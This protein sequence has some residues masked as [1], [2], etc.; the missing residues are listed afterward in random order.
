MERI[1]EF[2][3]TLD[4]LSKK[5]SMPLP[6]LSEPEVEIESTD[7]EKII[8]TG[9]DESSKEPESIVE[10]VQGETTSQETK[11]NDEDGF[12]K[13]VKKFFFKKLEET[14]GR[15]TFDKK[16]ERNRHIEFRVKFKDPYQK[17]IRCGSRTV[18]IASRDRAKAELKEIKQSGLIRKCVSPGTSPLHVVEKKDTGIHILV[19]KESL[20]EHMEV[21][22]KVIERLNK[23]CLIVG[24]RV[25][26]IYLK[27]F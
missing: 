4:E 17:P 16:P 22:K 10:I 15:T 1:P 25:R 20:E 5:V 6:D 9:I 13:Q 23:N 24:V 3:R 21:G 7:E 27:L 8:F 14:A 11:L 12:S 19:K 26:E 18:P 2:K